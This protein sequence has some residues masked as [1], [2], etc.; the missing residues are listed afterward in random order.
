MESGRRLFSSDDR[1][2]PNGD[3][4]WKLGRT[5]YEQGWQSRGAHLDDDHGTGR[6]QFCHCCA[7]H[8]ASTPP[9]TYPFAAHG[10]NTLSSALSPPRL[11]PESG[12]VGSEDT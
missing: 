12:A 3:Q 11:G 7:R 2:N 8:P 6:L 9:V 4:S 5:T 10:S 1:A